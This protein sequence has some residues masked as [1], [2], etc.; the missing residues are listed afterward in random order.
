VERLTSLDFFARLRWLDGAPLL[1]RV[2]PYRQRIFVQ[3]LDTVDEAGRP[4]VNLVLTGRAKKNWKSADLVLAALFCLVTDAPAGNECYLL[5]NDEDQAGDD[6]SLAKKLV[7]VNPVLSDWLKPCAK[8]IERRDGAG[9]LEILPAQDIVGTHGKTFRFCGFD[10]IH[11]YRTWDI[12]EAMQPDPTRLDAL[13]W[14]TSYASI[15]HRPGVPLF[16]LCLAGRRGDDPRMLFSWYAGDYTTDPDCTDLDP[17]AR[18]NPSRTSW[19]DPGYLEQQRR[20]LPSHKFRRLH[21]NLPGLPEGSAFQP[22]PVMDSVERGASVR[23]PE[24]GIV[25]KAFVDMSGGS[26][27]D[28][29][30]DVGYV[31][32]DGRAVH[33]RILDQGPR[34]PFD[35][36][37][38]VERFVKV[39]QEYGCASVTGDA[40]AGQ[41]FRCDFERL[42]VAYHVAQRTA[43]EHYEAL[44]PLLNSHRV[45][46]PDVPT[47]EQQL[48][49]L[50]W[51]GGK[52]DH[53]AG[54][55]D[56]YAAAAAGL[57]WL[58]VGHEA[59]P[60]EGF[61]AWMASEAERASTPALNHH[62]VVPVVVP[63]DEEARRVQEHQKCRM[64]GFKETITAGNRQRCKRCGCDLGVARTPAELEAIVVASRPIHP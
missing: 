32:A 18:A 51:R 22:E 9:F 52:I 2:E 28:A 26:N 5:A 59:Q 62:D 54:E 49:G 3:V 4:C 31:G 12:L 53:P 41:T 34:P 13:T 10:E 19:N 20:R 15:Y 1:P 50:V 46:L 17:E 14:I 7:A 60:G 40:Y 64:R 38:A 36:R 8:V 42:G 44:E 58:L 21:L 11:G 35:P 29:V 48:L 37:K 25:Y 63:E 45:I 30:L 27:D 47:L 56:D 61:L 57:T 39:L 16:D 6:L 55:H 33:A 23:R 43:S 24:P